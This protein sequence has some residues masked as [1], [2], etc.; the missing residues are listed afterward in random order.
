[1]VRIYDFNEFDGMPY[2]SME[3]IEGPSL[4]RKLCEGPMNFREAAELVQKL[5]IAVGYAH[6]QKVVHRDL[7]PLNVLFTK[8]DTPKITDFGLPKALDNEQDQLTHTDAVM[9]TPSYMAPEQASGCPAE[10]GPHTDIYALGAI[11]YEA[12]TGTPPYL[13]ENKLKTL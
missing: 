13:G 7:K 1:I 8:D 12:L 4:A 9:G 2:L 5:A 3:L 6:T 10:I 11:L